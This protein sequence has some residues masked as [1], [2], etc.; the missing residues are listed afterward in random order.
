[1]S[2]DFNMSPEQIILLY[3]Q[4]WNLEVTFEEVRKHLGVETQKLLS[5]SNAAD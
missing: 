3:I 1:M 5:L 2:T 4:R